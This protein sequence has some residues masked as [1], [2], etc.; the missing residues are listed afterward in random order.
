MRRSNIVYV[1]IR[2]HADG[3]D[4]VLLHRHAK[5]GDC[6][7]VGGH[8]EPDEEADWAKAATRE[9]AE[10]LAPLRVGGDFEVEPLRIR[11]SWG[12]EPSR[13][14][15]G[16]PTEYSAE[17]YLLRFK[18][19]PR[20]LLAALPAS[21]FRLVP[22]DAVRTHD[23][24]SHPVRVLLQKLGSEMDFVPRSWDPEL[25]LIPGLPAH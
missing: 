15:Y 4:C 17:Y 8:V 5:W 6:T 10:E 23:E 13:S 18:K 24:V 12:P 11:V 20:E 7:L 14:A 16:E 25:E 1:L 2:L 22:L 9:A 19:D 3:E 21:E